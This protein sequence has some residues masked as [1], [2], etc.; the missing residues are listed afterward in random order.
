MA[1]VLH[2][3]L[4]NRPNYDEVTR[5]YLG[6][7]SAF[8]PNLL[9]HERVRRQFNAALDMMNSAVDGQTVAMPAVG[10]ASAYASRW[11]DGA[12][13]VEAG[14]AGAGGSGRGVGLG[15]GAGVGAG[16]ELSLRDLVARF[17]EE[18][19]VQFMPKFGRYHDGLQVSCPES[20]VLIP[21]FAHLLF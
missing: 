18:A 4:S 20:P 8:P 12:D 17:A 21:C 3:W 15:S 9:D 1:Q 11:A 2:Y 14:G 19:G 7:K 13:G 6:W 16:V 10:P 5:W